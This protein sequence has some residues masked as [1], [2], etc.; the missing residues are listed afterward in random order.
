MNTRADGRATRTKLL[1]AARAIIIDEGTDKLTIDRVIKLAQT[2]KGSFLYHFP[3]RDHLLEA[4]VD[5]YAAHLTDVQTKLEAE[6]AAQASPQPLLASYLAWYREFN[7]GE[8]DQGASPL[9]A[10]VMA[11]RKNRR[12]LEPVRSWYR[13]YFD[14]LE[15]SG[16]AEPFEVPADRPCSR[17]DAL[18]LTLAMDALFFHKL[19]GTDVL[20]EAERADVL[21]RIEE[22][23]GY[24]R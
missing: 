15:A 11:S 4:L 21:A 9:V 16:S 12:F 19:F 20:S 5:G 6:A 14:R 17:T 10:L 22:I 3:S 2:S 1:D 8:I 24:R 13:D 7:K 23:A 18:L